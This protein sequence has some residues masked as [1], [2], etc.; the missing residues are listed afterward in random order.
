MVVLNTCCI[1]ENADNKLYG[2]LGHLKSLKAARP[3]LEIVVGGLPGPEGPRPDPGAGPRTSTWCS[4]PTTC[5]GPSSCSTRSRVDGPLTEIWR[6]PSLDEAEAFPSALPAR[7]ATGFGAWVTIQIGCDNSLCLLH[8]AR[9]PRAARSAGPSAELVR[10]GRG[11]GRR[12]RGRDHAAR[13]ERELLRPG[14]DDRTAHRRTRTP[15]RAAG[16]TAVGCRS[17]PPGPPAVRRPAAARSPRSRASAGSATPA[18][19]PRTCAPRPSRRWPTIRRCARTCTCPCSRAA[20][21]CW[22]PCTAATPP[23]ATSSGWL[24][25]RAAIARP[26]RHHRPHRRVPRR[27]RGRL[28]AHPRGGGRGRL[29][30]RLHVH[31][32]APTGHRG[33][34]ARRPV[35]AGR[36]RGRPLRPAAGRGRA[37]RRW[38]ATR[39]GSAGSRRS[40]VEGPSKQG[41]GGAERPHPAEQA[42]ALRPSRPSR[43]A[44]APSPTCGSRPAARTTSLGELV[45]VTAAPRHRTRI[46]VASG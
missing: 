20:T 1:R 3:G 26:G 8:R 27:D 6:R 29:R 41:P 33:G 5:T 44:R 14:P 30:Q 11:A 4:A 39:P 23:S 31:L 16:R 22:R 42:R 18:R 13:P 46:P 40:L 12:R 10:R 2:T 35:R 43:S 36:R 19:I 9:R 28:R 38:P 17:P 24:P 34:R 45:E 32:L 15:G 37:L 21:P 7:R 25:A